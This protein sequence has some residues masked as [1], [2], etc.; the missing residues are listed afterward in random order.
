MQNYYK[1]C[2]NLPYCIWINPLFIKAYNLLQL[3]HPQNTKITAKVMSEKFELLI[4]SIVN[5]LPKLL[6]KSLL[7]KNPSWVF[8]RTSKQFK[9]KTQLN[10]YDQ[11][12][13]QVFFI[14]FQRELEGS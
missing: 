11:I 4:S 10:N 7:Y 8:D 5:Q 2:K 12:Q 14:C 9:N 1:Q 13:L 3:K 6:S